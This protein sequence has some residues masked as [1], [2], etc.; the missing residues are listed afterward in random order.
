MLASLYNGQVHIWNYETQVKCKVYPE[1]RNDENNYL[2]DYG[3]NIRGLR[4]S[5]S[6]LQIRPKEKLGRHR[7]SK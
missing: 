7:F 6:D 4:S 3:E 1:K 2:A 5:S